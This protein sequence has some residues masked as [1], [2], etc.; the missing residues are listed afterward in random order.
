MECTSDC[1]PES[2]SNKENIYPDTEG[3]YS[4]NADGVAVREDE[5]LGEARDYV[6]QTS[7]P[8]EQSPPVVYPAPSSQSKRKATRIP[9]YGF[10]AAKA[11][12]IRCTSEFCYTFEDF[13]KT[14]FP[15]WTNENPC[16]GPADECYANCIHFMETR[17]CMRAYV[18]RSF[19]SVQALKDVYTIRKSGITISSIL[20]F[21]P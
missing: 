1:L 15:S 11:R 20:G 2:C 6:T 14:F 18:R 5:P 4:W 7:H 8:V 3:E 16:P 12:L 10:K 13:I 9:N 19:P 17:Y 21:A